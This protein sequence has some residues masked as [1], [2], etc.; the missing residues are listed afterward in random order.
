MN[1]RFLL[2][3]ASLLAVLPACSDDSDRSSPET[4][5]PAQDAAADV[6]TPL[7]GAPDAAP[8]DAV[9]DTAETGPDAAADVS[10][11]TAIEAATEAGPEA[12]S[13][14]AA[15]VVDPQTPPDG[16]R[17][18]LVAHPYGPDGA[19]CGRLVRVVRMDA[20]GALTD[21]GETLDVGDCPT[22]VRFAPDGRLA[23]VIV[24]NSHNPGAG[25]QRVVVLRNDAAGNVSIVTELAEFS[26]TNPIEVSFS[27]DG[28]KAYVPDFDMS[29]GGVHVIDVIPGCTAT[30]KKKIDMPL[31]HNVQP[32][33]GGKYAFVMGN[34][35]PL[36]S[37]LIDLETE[38]VVDDYDLF[39]DW[40]DSYT[41]SLSP[42]GKYLAVPNSSPFSS[43]AE[44]VATI[45][46]DTSGAKPVPTLA[47][48][49]PNVTEPTGVLWSP[50]GTKLLVSTFSGNKVHWMNAGA[51]G[52]LSVGGTLTGI[53]LASYVSMVER[54]KNK[55]L[56]LV[57]S[58]TSIHALR[59]TASGIE[60]S[61]E[62]SFGSGNGAIPN[63]VAVEP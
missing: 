14:A 38:T 34:K 35:D 43:L 19:T 41:V 37:A 8:E 4:Q 33:P 25:M 27:L 15:C 31:P 26:G 23:F 11:D 3:L 52:E 60:K 44:T 39:S 47:F 22:R 2:P 51:G 62:L 6:V 61:T 1:A 9:A 53:G 63:D 16:A 58:V 48:T 24:S 10:G 59:F 49:L 17:T 18:V 46:L 13:D 45:E 30:Y 42:D 7:D 32:L 50:D 5:V 55:G 36:D 20:D 54:G 40:T 29:T 56:V 21:T 12:G 28:T 57:T